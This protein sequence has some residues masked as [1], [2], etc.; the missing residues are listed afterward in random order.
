MRWESC[1]V[2]LPFTL[3][4]TR[5]RGRDLMAGAVGAVILAT[6]VSMNGNV[7]EGEVGL[8][9]PY[10]SVHPLTTLTTTL[11]YLVKSHHTLTNQHCRSQ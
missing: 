3:Q 5:L 7:K 4:G 11:P 8:W 10:H 1:R 2:R 6:D 9:S